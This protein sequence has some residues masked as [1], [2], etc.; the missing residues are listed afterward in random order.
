MKISK[1][2]F[3]C[4]S[5]REIHFL[6]G[7]HPRFIHWSLRSLPP[8]N[9]HWTGTIIT[10]MK[11]GI[12]NSICASSVVTGERT[13]DS[14]FRLTCNFYFQGR[15]TLVWKHAIVHVCTIASKMNVTPKGVILSEKLQL[16]AT[17]WNEMWPQ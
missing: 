10:T 15:E 5:L 17:L 9:E 1:L 3:D 14:T 2:Y 12:G 6:N 4:Y 13:L 16:T 7:A 11:L 8:K